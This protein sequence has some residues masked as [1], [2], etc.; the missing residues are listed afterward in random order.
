MRTIEALWNGDINP[1]E[2]LGVYD[3]QSRQL[4]EL[5]QR[6]SDNLRRDMTPQQL[7]LFEKYTQRADQYLLRAIELAFCEGFCTG[8]RLFAEGLT[9]G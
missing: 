6:S 9:A 7:E 5:M 3:P 2:R 4:L 1:S 8:G